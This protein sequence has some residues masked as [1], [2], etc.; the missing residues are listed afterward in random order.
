MKSLLLPLLAALALPTAV[1]ADYFPDLKV[2]PQDF[3][4]WFHIGV[5]SGSGGML[6]TMWAGSGEITLESAINWRDGILKRYSKEGKRAKE[7]SIAGFNQGIESIQNVY[8]VDPKFKDLKNR[9]NKC[10]KLKI[11]Q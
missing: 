10:N 7:I 5:I 9:F 1:N 11:K 3:S 8:A 6:C 2:Q 4:E